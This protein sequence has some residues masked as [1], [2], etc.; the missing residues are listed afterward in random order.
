M[1]LE[2]TLR[3]NLGTFCLDTAFAVEGTRIG[4]FGPSGSGKSTLFGL[5]AGLIRP[6]AGVIRLD[7]DILFDRTRGIE[8]PPE[9]RRIGVVFQQAHLFPHLSV[10]RNL[11][12][13]WQRLT[14][15]ER[16]IDPQALITVL[17]LET[18]LDR[19]VTTLSGGERQRVALGRAVL[20]CP[21][22][23][24]MDEPLT[25][26][27][28]ISQVPDYPL[29]QPG[30]RRVCHPVPVYL[31]RPAGDSAANRFSAGIRWR[32]NGG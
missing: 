14:S 11:L 2:V 31:P 17:H 24:I 5:L 13:G 27:D 15:Q 12:Y 1:K 7:D 10:R 6:D 26:L 22:L 28:E 20:A 30:L 25:G 16:R 8:L 21:R 29:P 32:P 19:K 3:K 4:V 23:L 9:K 18:L